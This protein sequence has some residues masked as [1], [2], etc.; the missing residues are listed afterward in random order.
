MGFGADGGTVCNTGQITVTTA[1]QLVLAANAT[2][3]RV[4]LTVTNASTVASPISMYVGA[5]GV[6]AAT[7]HAIPPA[8]SWTTTYRGPLYVIASAGGT[9]TY[10]E[11]VN[12]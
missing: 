10:F 3:S 7:G 9:L 11:E 1:A 2:Q 8:T 5:S 6:T 12:A 4:S